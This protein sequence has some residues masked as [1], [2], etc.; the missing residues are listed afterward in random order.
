MSVDYTKAAPNAMQPL[1]L[2]SG[3]A[4]SDLFSTFKK[5]IYKGE[6]VAVDFNLN[7]KIAK[8]YFGLISARSSVALKGVMTHVGIMDS[9]FFGGGRVILTNIGQAPFIINRGDRIGQ[10]TLIKYS[11][12]NWIK[13]DSFK[14]EVFN[15]LSSDAQDRHT[16]FGST[17]A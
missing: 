13:S 15:W 8:G 9:H 3:A 2:T 4:G 6:T 10:R 7:I 16:G 11:K 17:G 5:T 12:A 14:A 1:H